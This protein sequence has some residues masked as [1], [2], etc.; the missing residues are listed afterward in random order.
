[1]KFTLNQI[2]EAYRKL[3]SYIYYD[4]FSLLKKGKLA[5]F[6][7]SGTFESDLKK[8]VEFL[9]DPNKKSNKEYWDTLINKIGFH[10]VPKTYVEDDGDEDFILTNSFVQ[11]NYPVK[12]LNYFID[13]PIELHIISVLW[14]L[15][16][17][18][19]LQSDYYKNNYAYSLEIDRTK[20]KV[21]DGLRLFS[22]YF[23][24]YQKWRDEG[25]KTAQQFLEKEQDVLII[26][27]DIK[28]YFYNI[29]LENKKN[30]LKGS[31]K[32]KLKLPKNANLPFTDLVLEINSTYSNLLPE[33][34]R[35]AIPI[36]L[37]SSGI[38]ANWFLK[39][40]DRQIVENLS[41]A[42]YGRYVDDIMIV[43][44]N[45]RIPILK[46]TIKEGE[47]ESSIQ[48]TFQKYFEER[49]ILESER[50]KTEKDGKEFEEITYKWKE[51][52]E[53]KIQKSKISLQ[54]FNSKESKA[55]LDRFVK[56]IEK[57]SSAFW[58]LPD[59][60]K[61]KDDFDESVYELTY[62]DTVNK[63]RSI[64]QI[65][66]DRYGASIFLAKKIKVSLLSESPK[67]EKTTEQILTFFRGR[68]NLEFISIWEKVFA[69]FVIT[70]DIQS[71]WSFFYECIICIDRTSY[72]KKE[73]EDKIKQHQKDF[74]LLAASMALALD[75]SF[76]NE[77]LK[78]NLE[79]QKFKWCKKDFYTSLELFSNDLRSANMMRHN[80][81]VNII[82]NF[83]ASTSNKSFINYSAEKIGSSV[84]DDHKLKFSPR[85][86]FFYEFS[87]YESL[88][89]ILSKTRVKDED[90]ND[91]TINTNELFL[92]KID[93]YS[94]N[95]VLELAFESFYR[96]NYEYRIP[97]ER[98][99]PNKKSKL[100]NKYFTNL[101]TRNRSE[102]IIYDEILIGEKYNKGFS[103][104]NI[105]VANMFVD[106]NN[107]ECSCFSIPNTSLERRKELLAILNFAEK[108][109]SQF[110]V[111]PEVS[112]PHRWAPLIADESRRK[113]RCIIVGLEHININDVCFNL[114]Q[115]C[116]PINNSGIKD[117]V[118][119][120]R[121]KNHYSPHE[122]RT[123][124]YRNKII[125]IPKPYT[126]DKIIWNKVHFSSY[127][128]YELADIKHRTIFRSEV[129][130]LFASEYNKDINYFSNIVE[131]V[132]R[133]VHCYFIQ[134]NSSDFGDSRITYPARTEKKDILRLKGGKNNVVLCDEIDLK[135]IREFQ[136][137]KVDGQNTMRFKNTPPDY[138]HKKAEE[139][140][141]D[142]FLND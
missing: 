52:H 115:S 130:L 101:K 22:P 120:F 34:K 87:I 28:E 9:N 36:G 38:I 83:T 97:E 80:Y 121:L 56:N 26:G 88:K 44:A 135:I 70:N 33:D 126:Y 4:N 61:I 137:T 14:I 98:R 11:D 90:V 125:P 140:L 16:E 60:D 17:G 53:I 68:M 95:V 138:D 5:Q 134:A 63:L 66:K 27:L 127:N 72:V 107:V 79:K 51:N 1:M 77:W 106:S 8:I 86:I 119:I 75:Q 62:T 74:L 20:N 128:C 47:S 99:R 118:I 18:F 112:T 108:N 71:F 54:E 139:R 30:D 42:Y 136:S 92:K 124:R 48:R 84:L 25:V 117:A 133:D 43:L 78:E 41:P 3:K 142:F 132:S 141:N 82:Q 65:K 111:L 29:N 103:K 129:D 109:K 46:K 39:E 58:F 81:V 57:N 37:L 89:A 50:T 24:Q 45:S 131:S 64:S 85:Y 6:E 113:Q 91:N 31:I 104:I 12:K 35:N 122:S 19:V 40:F 55:V 49:G 10:L 100:K 21:V 69:Y 76:L 123:L 105:S 102:T 13:A 93:G 2:E 23:E 94:E 96:T 7:A 114:T 73:V 110:L 59:E 32:K 15:Y 116:M 67:D